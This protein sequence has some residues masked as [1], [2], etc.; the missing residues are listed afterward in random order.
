ML[1]S[2][3]IFRNERS[4]TRHV[5]RI[6]RLGHHNGIDLCQKIATKRSYDRVLKKLLHR[7]YG[8]KV[9]KTAEPAHLIKLA[10]FG[11]SSQ[12]SHWD[13]WSLMAMSNQYTCILSPEGV[14]SGFKRFIGTF[15]VE[16][17]MAHV[18]L[19]KSKDFSFCLL[20]IYKIE[21]VKQT[22]TFFN[23][24]LFY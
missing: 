12:E 9:E 5:R 20:L 22:C 19:F 10:S 23:E 16:G 13:N 11:L 8:I 6:Q 1:S 18:K 3:T 2:F 21:S 15:L 24:K 4:C 7:C 14:D 17:K